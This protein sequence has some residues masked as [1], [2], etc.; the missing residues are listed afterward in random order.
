MFWVCPQPVTVPDDDVDPLIYLAYGE[1]MHHF[2]IFDLTLV[3]L[4]SW[5]GEP[6][7]SFSERLAEVDDLISKATLGTLIRKVKDRRELPI[8]VVDEL[9]EILSQRN[10]LAHHFLREYFIIVPS[11]R[12]R[13]QAVDKL[14]ETA[15]RLESLEAALEDHLRRLGVPSPDDLDLQTRAAIDQL[16]PTEWFGGD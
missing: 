9:C 7:A 12:V 3:Q 6:G 16:R 14:A 8:D 5:V 11:E 10:Y 4:I 2:Q 13:D 15:T 1:L